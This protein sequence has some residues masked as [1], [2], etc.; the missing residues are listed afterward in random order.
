[1][2]SRA[3]DLYQHYAAKIRPIYQKDPSLKRPFPNSI[4]C[5]TTYNF[6]PETVCLPHLDKANLAYGKCSITGLGNYDYKR[7]GHLV[8]WELKLVVEFPPGATVLIPSA[9]ITHSNTPI[10][11]GET[12]YSFTQYTAGTLFRWVEN[13]FMTASSYHSV[14]TEEEQ[15][16][17]KEKDKARWKA[18]ISLLPVL[19]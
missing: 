12:R 19:V 4:F 13:G 18:G 3:P 9:V 5:A 15:E 1:M 6:G 16:Q 17:E 11:P 10:S 8:L 7:G 14:L 2:A